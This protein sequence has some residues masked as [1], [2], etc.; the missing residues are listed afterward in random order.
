METGATGRG[1]GAGPPGAE[2]TEV[3]E[4]APAG[5]A[6]CLRVPCPWQGPPTSAPSQTPTFM[7]S[8]PTPGNQ[9]AL[10]SA[11]QPWEPEWIV[12]F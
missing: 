12:V 11:H 7:E 10:S 6:E 2:L 8:S 5:T 3:G 1:E 4:G 9:P